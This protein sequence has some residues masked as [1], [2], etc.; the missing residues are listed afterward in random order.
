MTCGSSTTRAPRPPPRPEWWWRSA[1]RR[2]RA[3]G[4]AVQLSHEAAPGQ[5]EPS[6]PP[7]LNARMQWSLRGALLA[8]ASPRARRGAARRPACRPRHLRSRAGGRRGRRDAA[9]QR[10]RGRRSVHGRRA[11]RSRRGSGASRRGRGGRATC[12]ATSAHGHRRGARRRRN[13]A[14]QT[15]SSTRGHQA[16]QPGPC[17]IGLERTPCY[18]ST[19]NLPITYERA[20]HYSD[21][22]NHMKLIRVP[23]PIMH[24]MTTRSDCAPVPSPSHFRPQLH[25]RT[26]LATPVCWSCRCDTPQ[27]WRTGPSPATSL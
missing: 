8:T 2:W 14:V 19:Q 24:S 6:T 20:S 26:M 10:R 7:H 9:P 21:F 12:S 23:A 11:A 27:R 18:T 5:A 3:V 4:Q 16:V 13:V 25:R 15:G 17:K 22:C 1:H